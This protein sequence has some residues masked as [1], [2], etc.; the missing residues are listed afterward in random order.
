MKKAGLEVTV[1][2]TTFKEKFLFFRTW[3]L[4]TSFVSNNILL[5]SLNAD[6]LGYDSIAKKESSRATITSGHLITLSLEMM[7][8]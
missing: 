8:L 5:V 2:K 3:V 4:F 1:G 7:K 6:S